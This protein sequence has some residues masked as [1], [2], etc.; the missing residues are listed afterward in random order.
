MKNNKFLLYLCVAIFGIVGVYLTFFSGNIDKYD[1][2]TVAY[3][4][5]PNE[6]YDDDS[7]VY[8]PIYY[9]KVRGKTYKCEAKTG[10]SFYPKESKNKVYFDS[11]DPNKCKTQYEKSTGSFAGIVCLIVAVILGFFII[12]KPS[13]DSNPEN[14]ISEID[15]EK[16]IQMEE[17]IEKAEAVIEKVLLIVKRIILGIIIAILLIFIL[18]ESFIV[19]QTFQAKDYI[20]TTA[21]LVEK[22]DDEE[23]SVF[24]DYIYTFEDK[25]GKQ[26][27]IVI[28]MSKESTAKDQV[29]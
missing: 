7:T 10:S 5:E 14:S 17:N 27:N 24:D 6:K 15:T 16:R 26:Q 4:I 21:I 25:E 8:Y 19:K 13:L 29:K 1:S 9:F 23:D 18:F 2:Q 11:K 20:E 12:K 3:K 28:S 22:K